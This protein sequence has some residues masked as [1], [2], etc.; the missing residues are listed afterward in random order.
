M[1]EMSDPAPSRRW[2]LRLA[3][4]A[5]DDVVG[6]RAEL[7]E[8]MAGPREFEAEDA[9]ADR[10]DDDRGARQHDH[11]DADQDD[12]AA[13]DGDDDA[14]RPGIGDRAAQVTAQAP[15]H[16]SVA[17]TKASMSRAIARGAS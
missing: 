6:G 12:A 7:A 17:P 1:S 16:G 11:R 5:I 13:D 14:P 4:N 9:E 15:S 3:A 2:R 10:D 8:P